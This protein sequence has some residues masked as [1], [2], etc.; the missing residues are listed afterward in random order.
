MSAN[1]PKNYPTPFEVAKNLREAAKMVC[2]LLGHD[3]QTVQPREGT[4]M[5]T[6]IGPHVLC[7][8]CCKL[9]R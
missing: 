3:W 7:V 9:N 8:R 2:E 1:D 5:S 6:I 4:A